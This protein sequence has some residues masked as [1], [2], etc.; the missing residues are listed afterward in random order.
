MDDREIFEAILSNTKDIPFMKTNLVNL[1][2]NFSRLES[3][4]DRIEED[5]ADIHV[6]ETNLGN[7][8]K[9]ADRIEAD[10]KNIRDNH[11]DHIEKSV[12]KLQ[13]SQKWSKWLIGAACTTLLSITAAIVA[14]ILK[15]AG[16]F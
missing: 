11:I 2:N 15:L 8:D 5:V 1:E 6:I 3:K 16:L 12:A 4:V 9:K 13:E 14:G 10:V 7:L